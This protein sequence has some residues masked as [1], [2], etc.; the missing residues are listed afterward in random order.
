MAFETSDNRRERSTIARRKLTFTTIVSETSKA[1]TIP[2]N[3]EL[4]NYVIDAPA[5]STDTDF[6]L[7]VTNEDSE[8]VYENTSIADVVST[9]VLLSATPIPM[10]GN[11]TFTVSFTTAQVATFDLYLY[12]K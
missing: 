8:T 1:I 9:L 4:L 6:D 3:G 2:I 7:T 11:L 10:A 12:Y 5:L